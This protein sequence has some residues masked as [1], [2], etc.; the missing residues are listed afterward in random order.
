MVSWLFAPFWFNPMAFDGGKTRQ[1]M[2]NWLLWMRRKDSSPLLSWEAWYAEEHE[3]LQTGSWMKRL[4]VLSPGFRYAL[5]FVGLVASLSEKQLHEGL[6]EELTRYALIVG[7][8]LGLLLLL[9]CCRYALRT[10]YLTMRIASTFLTV[11]VVLAVPVV[12]SAFSLY[13]ILL[14]CA[15]FGYFVAAA[16]RVFMMFGK[17]RAVLLPMQVYDYLCGGCLIG[18]CLLLS[19]PQFCRAL[20]TKSLLSAVFERRI[21]HNEIMRLLATGTE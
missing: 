18:L 2:R 9:L 13:K 4:H 12:L 11:A 21:A 16:T 6:I 5:T 10:S 1:D 8:V 20:Q 17:P 15:A 3:Y 14:L 7:S 19:V